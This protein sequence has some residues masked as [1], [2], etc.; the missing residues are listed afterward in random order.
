MSKTTRLYRHMLVGMLLIFC[1]AGCDRTESDWK[2]AKDLN[3]PDAY[4]AFLDKHPQGPHVDDAR[5]L[6]DD[7]DF[8][9]ASNQNDTVSLVAYSKNNPKG[10][11]LQEVGILR[12]ALDWKK[13]ESTNSV[14]LWRAFIVTYP[15]SSHM[16]EAED[17]VANGDYAKAVGEATIGA[18]EGFLKRWPNSAKVTDANVILNNLK[19]P[20]DW[21]IAT[22]AATQDAY[23]AYVNAH[24]NTSR[25]RIIRGPVSASG[26]VVDSTAPTR[27]LVTIGTNPGIEVVLDGTSARNFGLLDYKPPAVS[28]LFSRVEQNGTYS[29]TH[30][31]ARVILSVDPSAP[32]ILA[33][34]ILSNK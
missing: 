24:P 11:H 16:A 15:K 18:L 19:E 5:N 8:V 32:T 9:I 22:K 30:P 10:R 1:M 6:K 29:E 13:A 31:N 17:Y 28:E 12:E 21:A 34:D 3:T 27:V 33:V 20:D 14:E 2:K 7:A 4:A 26:R 23:R 25:L